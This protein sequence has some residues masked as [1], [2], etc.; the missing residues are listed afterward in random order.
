MEEGLEIVSE[1]VVAKDWDESVSSRHGRTSAFKNSQHRWLFT[2][3]D[4]ARQYS[5]NNCELYPSVRSCG[6]KMA[7]REGFYLRL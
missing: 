5:S 6:Q 4:K 1:P 2:R 7:S 3:Q